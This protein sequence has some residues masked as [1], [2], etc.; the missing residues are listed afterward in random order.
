MLKV[1]I[2]AH[3]ALRLS[4]CA[5]PLALLLAACAPTGVEDPSGVGGQSTSR[6]GAIGT[7]GSAGGTGGAGTGTGGVSPP[8]GTGGSAAPAGTG[9]SSTAG[10]A[11]GAGGSS[12]GGGGSATT[13][14]SGSTGAAGSAAGTG[15]AGGRGGAA[16]ATAGR[17]GNAGTGSGGSGT[18][19]SGT[20]G[21]GTGGSAPGGTG[22]AVTFQKAAGT[23]PNSP[24]PASTV[25]LP[26]ADWQ[27]GII[28]PS[29]ERW[30][31][32][33]PAHRAQ[34]LPDDRRQRGVLD[35]RRV[36]PRGAQAALQ[37]HDAQPHRRGGREPHGLVRALRK[38]LLHG[39][40]RRPRHQ[41]LG[42]HQRDGA[43]AHQ[44]GRDSGHELRRLHRSGLGR[45]LAGAVHLRR[46]HQQRH[47]GRRRR[48]SRLGGDRQR[49]PHVVVRR[50]QRRPAR[51]DR[52]RPGR[53]D[54]ERE[55]RRRDP[56]HQRSDQPGSPR[57]VHDRQGVHRAVPP[58][59]RVPDRR[60]CVG[61][62][63]EPEEHRQR[64]GADRQSRD[65][66]LRV[67]GLPGRLHVPRTP[68]HRD[69]RNARRLEDQR[70]RSAQHEGHEPHLG[71]A[72]PRRQERRPVRP[73]DRQP[74]GHRRRSVA[75]SG[76]V[77]RRPSDRARHE[78]PGGRHGHPRQPGD[79]RLD[80]VADRR[81]VLGQHRARDR[82]RGQLHRPPRG[83][84]AAAGQVGPAHGRA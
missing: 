6:G 23:I 11:G 21:S 66:G 34:R 46:R 51:R 62:A 77:H 79:R 82:E 47:Q 84:A 65:R 78:G 43:Q 19:G 59:L 81:H 44:G 72:E 20:A 28:S 49:D 38:H 56:G 14:T 41:H 5:A 63:D 48:Q 37:L 2:A 60:Q 50:R 4:A 12:S 35:P 17:G 36:E 18:A 58:A 64:H 40:D 32:D 33:Q 45:L 1:R 54:A 74:G 83:R 7:A 15:G 3:R 75:L 9:G 39:H 53:H 69:Q 71:T 55:R 26:K 30:A 27:K 8:G 73:A 70:R 68:A 42:R 16:G 29:H 13:G 76:L 52:Q 24:Q 61:R 57:V 31:P 10:G 25:N 67:H 80:Q 22:G